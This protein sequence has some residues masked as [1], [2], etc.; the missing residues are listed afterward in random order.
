MPSIIPTISAA[1]LGVVTLQPFPDVTPFTI[2]SG[3]TY[4]SILSGIR[5]WIRDELVPYL[6][7]NSAQAIFQSN[8]DTMI[9]EVNTALGD[10]AKT[11]TDALNAAVQEVITADIPITAAL[12]ETMGVHIAPPPSGGDD[13][14]AL[15]ELINQYGT[16]QLRAGTYRCNLDIVNR[17]IQPL[18]IGAGR[19]FTTLQAFD[20]S[21]PV[22]KFN[23]GS[24]S[25]AGGGLRSLLVDGTDR[26]IG[27]TVGI[28]FSGCG[29]VAVEDVEIGNCKV[30]VLWW[31]ERGSDFSEFDTFE[32]SIYNTTSP[33]V[34]RDDNGVESFHGSGPVGN[35]VVGMP[36]DS[37]SAVISTIGNALPYNAPLSMTVFFSN[38]SQ[39][40]INYVNTVSGRHASFYG[41]INI[42]GTGGGTLGNGTQRVLFAGT[43]EHFGSANTVLGNI[44]QC[45]KITYEG[46]NV[47][48]E[49]LP[50]K[51]RATLKN[52]P[53]QMFAGVLAGG[54]VAQIVVHVRQS[55]YD[56]VF[57]LLAYQ[58]LYDGTGNIVQQAQMVNIDNA[59]A[60]DPTF[61]W[62]NGLYIANAN[63]TNAFTAYGKMTVLGGAPRTDTLAQFA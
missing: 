32:G 31:N 53:T 59:T 36:S 49:L 19:K 62:N 41:R 56:K 44:Y 43:I 2:R 12:F 5:V 39:F 45:S 24:G 47:F 54:E 7:D 17:F 34:Y 27:S 37:T 63:F 20:T 22:V 33:F 8:V 25:I 9:D 52:T 55:N 42:E 51:Q 28:A 57:V 29:G 35:T 11:V 48:G 4:E 1:G 23:G 46:G 10:Q 26:N 40:L 50:V 60:G 21:K 18:I 30:G 38:S 16:V 58:S 14:A 13:T 61:T 3:A 15:L 6:Q